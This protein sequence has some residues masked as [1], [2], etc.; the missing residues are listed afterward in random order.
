MAERAP[1]E[2]HLYSAEHGTR[3]EK[4]SPTD[5]EYGHMD[6]T[7]QKRTFEGFVQFWIYLAAATAITLIFLAIFVA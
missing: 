4:M 6:I 7:E 2:E 5:Y 1:T 3:T